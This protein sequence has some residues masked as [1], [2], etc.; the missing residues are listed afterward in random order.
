MNAVALLALVALLG[1]A[2]AAAASDDAQTEDVIYMVD[3]RELRGQILEEK[4]DVI[5]FKYVDRNINIETTLTLLRD[6]IQSIERD[7]P[8]ASEDDS[9]DGTDPG[10]RSASGKDKDDDGQ[11]STYGARRFDEP[12]DES[13]TTFY[14]V[15]IK[16]QMGTDVHVDVYEEMVDDIREHDP[17]YVIFEMECLDAEDRLFS[18]IEQQDQSLL[19]IDMFRDLLNLLHDDM[20]DIPQVLWIHDSLGTSS[21][22]ALSWDQ[23]YMKPE[24]RLGGIA[25]AASGFAVADPE[26]R[27]KFREAYM[28]WLKGFAE[29]GGHDLVLMD[30][31]VRPEIKLSASWHGRE[32]EWIT[33]TSGEYVVDPSEDATITFTADQ[34]ED[35]RISSGTAEDMYDLALLLGIREF[36][37]LDGEAEAIFEDY[38]E[39]WRRLFEQTKDWWYDYAKYRE[40]A[41]GDEALKYLGRAKSTVERIIGAMERYEPV[42]MRFMMEY[43]VRKFDLETIVEVLREQIR[44]IRQSGRGGGGGRGGGSGLGR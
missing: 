36:R 40:W 9:D 7:V 6:E 30:A 19:A 41:Q 22:L 3:G 23:I 35:F 2:P 15:P 18:R 32:V 14:V 12:I 37:V 29:Y 26:V 11:E 17:D 39:D 21:I 4:D 44:S 31:M 25:K 38:T 8:I 33:D 20:R 16:G 5:V 27:A 24:A 34:A 10:K 28:G 43:G 1:G 13:V 42:E